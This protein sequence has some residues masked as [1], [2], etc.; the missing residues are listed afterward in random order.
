MTRRS[1]VTVNKAQ[2]SLCVGNSADFCM[3]NRSTSHTYNCNVFVFTRGVT[4]ARMSDANRNCLVG[5]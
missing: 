5:V 1:C 2:E 4:N 3:G